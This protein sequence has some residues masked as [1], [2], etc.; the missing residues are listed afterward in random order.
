MT[1][2]IVG[3]LA[4]W[5]MLT[6]DEECLRGI[7]IEFSTM[8]RYYTHSLFYYIGKIIFLIIQLDRGFAFL[9]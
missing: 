1:D 2:S 7:V 9:A 5:I 6:V 4:I 8:G 3:T